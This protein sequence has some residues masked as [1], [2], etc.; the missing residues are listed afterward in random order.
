MILQEEVFFDL[1]LLSYF[2][3]YGTGI[4][5]AQMIQSIIGDEKLQQDYAHMDDFQMNLD[6]LKSIPLENY[7]TMKVREYFDDNANSGVV[8]YIFETPEALIF[9]FRGSE[10]FDDIRY[11]TGWQDWM[12]NFRMFLK[13]PTYQQIFT[14]HQVHTTQI[15]KPFYLCGHSKGGNLALYCALT[16][17]KDLQEQLLGVITFNAPGITKEIYSLYQERIQDPSFKSKLTLFENENDC[18]SAFFEHLKQPY[19]IRSSMPCSNLE[20]LYHNHNLYA[21]KE[22]RNNSYIFAEKKSAITKVVYHF[23]N[24]FFVNLKEERLQNLVARMDDYFESGLSMSELYKVLIYHISKYTSL[25][26]DID[27]EEV[28]TI[29]FQDLIE[30]R[31]TKQLMEKVKNIQPKEALRKAYDVVGNLTNVNKLNELDVTQ[32][33]QGFIRNYELMMNKTT[34]NLQELLAQNNER[35]TQAM[36]AIRNRSFMHEQKA[37]EH[38][39]DLQT[40]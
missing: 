18:I 9:A 4:S 23:V 15:N 35:I 28:K 25:F 13:E 40:D 24:D 8:Y 31:K 20:Q 19:Y 16:M 5:V 21:M 36:R 30:R 26:E 17:R 32:I 7:E 33:T 11:E 12:D 10:A 37:E 6:L 27:Y 1:S 39:E 3:S 38:E 22:F 29:T 2:Q 34:Q 14:L